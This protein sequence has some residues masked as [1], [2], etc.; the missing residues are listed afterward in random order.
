[1]SYNNEGPRLGAVIAVTAA[2]LLAVIGIIALAMWGVP[3][4]KV[5]QRELRGQATLAEAEWDRKV[6]I[7]EA[8][9]KKESAALL[10]AA[11]VERAKGVAEANVIISESITEPYLRYLWIQG[12]HD[13]SSEIIYVP[14]E[15]NLPILEAQ[16][17]SHLA[18]E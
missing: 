11:E 5:W 15:A 6:A 16:R 18:G 2:G 8:K 7:E 13:G 12:L 14:T 3:T 17:L 10:A 4:Y 9:A 1:M